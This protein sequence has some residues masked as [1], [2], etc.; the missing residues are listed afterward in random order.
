MKTARTAAGRPLFGVGPQQT[1]G[2][3]ARDLVP[4]Q[5]DFSLRDA[6][7]QGLDARPGLQPPGLGQG[8]IEDHVGRD[9]IL[10]KRPQDLDFGGSASPVAQRRERQAPGL[11]ESQGLGGGR[12]VP[13]TTHARVPQGHATRGGHEREA[14][15]DAVLIRGPQRLQETILHALVEAAGHQVFT[16]PPGGGGSHGLLRLSAAG[17]VPPRSRRPP[18]IERRLDRGD[19]VGH[20]PIIEL[21]DGTHRGAR[22]LAHLPGGVVVHEFP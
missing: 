11:V 13:F 22:C 6:D 2:A 12:L 17:R 3:L 8:T 18:G 7:D 10:Q 9:Q 16:C 1:G 15:H 21:E 19:D 5:Q 4:A 14:A 20:R